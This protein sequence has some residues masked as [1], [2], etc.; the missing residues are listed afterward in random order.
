MQLWGYLELNT[1]SYDVHS[2]NRGNV[3]LF[4]AAAKRHSVCNDCIH[5]VG[6]S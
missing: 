2:F 5:F 1:G 6:H 3:D 4:G